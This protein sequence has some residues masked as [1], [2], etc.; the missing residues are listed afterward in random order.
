MDIPSWSTAPYGRACASC[1]QAKCKCMVSEAGGSCARCRRLNRDCYPARRTR[2]MNPMRR[3]VAAKTAQL[4]RRLDELTSLV[5]AAQGDGRSNLTATSANTASSDSGFSSSSHPGLSQASPQHLVYS[6]Q[7]PSTA[8]DASDEEIL[9]DF[10]SN[11]LPYLPFMYIPHACPAAEIK[12]EYPF[13]WRA[14]VTLHC[15]DMVRRAA[16]REELKATAARA[17]MVDCQRSMDLLFGIIVYLAWMGFERQPRRMSLGPYV[18]MLIGLVLDMGLNRPPPQSLDLPCGQLAKPSAGAGSCKPP[19]SLVRTAEERRAVLGSFI[20][21][22]AVSHSLGRTESLRW[23][24][25]MKECMDMLAAAKET[26]SDAVLVQMACAQIVVDKA[27]R[28][29]GGN[30]GAGDY[31]SAP[32]ALYL[33]GLESQLDGIREQMPSDAFQKNILLLYLHHAETTVYETALKSA[34]A[35]T[36]DMDLTRLG[37]LYACLSAV[38]NRFAVLLSLPAADFALH[39]STVIFPTSHSLLTLLR[40]STFEYPG[41]DLLTVRQTADLLS[42]TEQVADKLAHAADAV[43]FRNPTAGS[44]ELDCFT[45]TSRVLLGLRAGWAAR[46]PDVPTGVGVQGRRESLSSR[47]PPVAAPP[48]TLPEIDHELIDTWFPTH[49]LAWMAD[50]PP[51]GGFP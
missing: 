19:V 28:D 26:P 45:M 30:E 25:H 48:L 18:Q 11:R 13:L 12:A 41:W 6:P 31:H 20:V 17:L 50:F 44:D 35:N 38:Q 42:I 14:L 27:T 46:L 2:K 8:T 7:D 10:R 5:Q 9:D 22:S 37:H 24:G 49:D 39:P 4:E 34:P 15:K 47:T 1:A 33:K 21:C 23:T 16:L 36:N 3:S 43:G 29:L 40:L 51:F 32:A